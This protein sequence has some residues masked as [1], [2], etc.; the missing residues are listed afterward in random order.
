MIS[1]ERPL[2]RLGY[3]TA[4]VRDPKKIALVPEVQHALAQWIKSTFG[5][6]H[7][8]AVPGILI[9]GLA[10]AFYAKPR[11]TTDVDLLFL[12]DSDIPSGLDHFKRTRKGAFQEQQTHVEI[13]VC[14]PASINLPP[15]VARK[16]AQTADSYS[17]LKVASVE[18]M[19]V[20][21]LFGS[22][23]PRRALRDQADIQAILENFPSIDLSDWA[24]SDAHKQRLQEI[25]KLAQS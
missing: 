14:T 23:T 2:R 12:S 7:P 16:V 1:T 11:E 17:G 20:L 13:E 22:D 6:K 8:G 3:T 24:L 9:G 15:A 21:K 10:M 5:Y 4:A 19:V 25:M 18:G